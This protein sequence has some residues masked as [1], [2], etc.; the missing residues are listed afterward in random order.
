[1]EPEQVRKKTPIGFPTGTPEHAAEV[2]RRARENW[3]KNKD[4]YRKETPPASKGEAPPAPPTNYEWAVP[5]DLQEALGEKLT[6]PEDWSTWPLFH[7]RRQTELSKTTMTQYKSYYYKLPQRTIYDVVRVILTYPLAQQNQYAKAGLSYVCQH[8]YETIYE[9]QRKNLPGS[10]FYR[11]E[12]QRMMVFSELCKRTKRAT[13]ERHS[14]QVA[15]EE[16]LEATVEW[17]DWEELA[18]RFV[19]AMVTKK[20]ATERDNQEAMI[21]AVYS[22]IP[23]VRLDWNDIEVRRSKG[24]ATLAAQKGEAGKNIMYIAFNEAVVFWGEF[25]N[26]A[27]FG[28]Q[29]PLKQ[30]LP[31]TLVRVLKRVLPEGNSTPLRLKDFSTVVTRLAEQITGKAFSNRLMRSSYIRHYHEQHSRD[32]VDVEATKAVMRLMHQTNMEVH[33]AYHK[34]KT[35][36]LVNQTEE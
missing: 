8:L 12:L 28:D 7:V 6:V 23:P 26:A 18:K 19:K 22:M 1:M 34:T 11:N 32:G 20:D 3:H 33:M 25:K 31:V 30:V 21:A 15:S 2:K 13:Y 9:R 27:S 14:S 16:R 24:G 35:E 10:S 4:R 17:K 29:L 36:Q 5:A